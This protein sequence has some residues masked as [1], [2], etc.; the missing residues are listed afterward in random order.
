MLTQAKLVFA[1]LTL[2]TLVCLASNA[3]D[4]KAID[5]GSRRELFIDHLLID[6][7]DSVRLVLSHELSRA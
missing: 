3:A 5:I 4:S 6:K 1:A 7:L 2:R